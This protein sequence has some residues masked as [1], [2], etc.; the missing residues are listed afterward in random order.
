MENQRGTLFT[1]KKIQQQPYQPITDLSTENCYRPVVRYTSTK[2]G[3]WKVGEIL[4]RW[5]VD[6]FLLYF[7][8]G[9]RWMVGVTLVYKL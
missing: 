7:G 4:G 8:Y 1:K 9:V 5:K 3:R 6:D 2:F